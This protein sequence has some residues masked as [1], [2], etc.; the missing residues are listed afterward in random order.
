MSTEDLSGDDREQEQ[1]PGEAR[2]QQLITKTMERY[3]RL[4]RR[5]AKE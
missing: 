2:V 1:D 4:L 5:L 3:D